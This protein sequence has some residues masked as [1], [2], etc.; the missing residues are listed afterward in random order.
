MMAKLA[1]GMADDLLS[2]MCLARECPLLLAPAMNRQMW[3]NPATQRNAGQLRADGVHVLGPNAGS[4]ACGE[5]GEG[6]MLEV[7]EL[8]EDLGTFFTSKNMAGRRVVIT[9]GPTFEALDP[10]R[11]FTN[12]SSGKMGYALARAMRDAGAEVVLVSGPVALGAPRNV[13]VIAVESARQMHDAVM[14][15]V[16]GADCFVSVAAVADWGVAEVAKNKIKKD[17]DANQAPVFALITNPDILA[18]VARLPEP[19]YCVGFAAES[20]SLREFAEAKRVRKNIPLLVANLVQHAV[21]KDA[22]ELVLIDAKGSTLMPYASKEE[23]ARLLA[24][25]IAAR[26]PQKHP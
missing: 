7:A 15:A 14:R 26:L 25:E 10:V 1:H 11:G 22:A 19:P 16:P 13:T 4:Q 18:E 24:G 2:V 23:Q 9:A 8:I 3:A 6:R 21:Q 5:I 17:P 20:E 12:R